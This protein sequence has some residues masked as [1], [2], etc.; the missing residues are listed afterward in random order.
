[1]T[2]R[3]P[4][5][6]RHVRGICQWCGGAIELRLKKD[7]TPHKIQASMHRDCTAEYMAAQNP[8][9]FRDALIERDGRGCAVCGEAPHSWEPRKPPRLIYYHKAGPACDVEWR[10][11]LDVDHIVPLWKVADLPDDQRREYFKIG[12]LQL[13]CGHCHKRKSAK[14]AAERAHLKR[15][16]GDKKRRGRKIPSRP[17][18]KRWRRKVNRTVEAR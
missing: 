4:P 7:G 17:F 1:M 13:L 6:R 14:E 18:D 16:A 2:H 15:L 10:L 5:L 9:S 11:M 3:K 8:S 12:N